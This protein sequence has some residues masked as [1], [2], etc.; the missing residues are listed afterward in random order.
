MLPSFYSKHVTW[1]KH[2]KNV[3]GYH[4]EEK[5]RDDPNS[6]CEGDYGYKDQGQENV[7][8]VKRVKSHLYAKVTQLCKITFFFF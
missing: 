4:S 1:T 6:G 7:T 8:K 3:P 2:E 5:L